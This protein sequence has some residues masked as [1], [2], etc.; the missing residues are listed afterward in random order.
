MKRNHNIQSRLTRT[1]CAVVSAA[2]LVSNLSIYLYLRQIYN[3]ELVNNYKNVGENLSEQLENDLVNIENFARMVCFDT[4]LQTLMRKHLLYEDYMYYRTIREINSALAQYVAL[5]DDLIDD[6]Y[7]VDQE[8]TIISRNGFYADT[9]SSGWFG[10]FK[11]QNVNFSFTG[12]H[13]VDRR[14]TNFSSE[15]KKVISYIV[16]MFDLTQ[17]VK[18]SGLMGYVIVNIKYDELMG[19]MESFSEFQGMLFGRNGEKIGG[20]DASIE[21]PGMQSEPSKTEYFVNGTYYFLSDLPSADW[22][23]VS[24]VK[25]SVLNMQVLHVAVLSFG[26]MLLI[27]LCAGR[28]IAILSRNITGPLKTLTTGIR[29]FSEGNYETHVEV[30]S[31]DEVEKIAVVFNQMVDNIKRQMEENQRK[32][33]EKRKSQMRFLIAQIKPHFIYNSLNCIIYLARR[34]RNEDI[35]LYTRAFI[36]LLQV[37]IKADP[38]QKTP[39]TEEVEYLRNY[40][41]LI[42][43]RYEH[44]PEFSWTIGSSCYDMRL[45]VLIL[46]PLIENSVFHGILPSGEPGQIHLSVTRE[47][48]GVR[49][50]VRDDGCGIDPDRLQ[51]IREE[52][53]TASAVSH[54]DP[55]IGLGNVNDRLKLC[56]GEES[57]LHIESERGRGTEVWF[58]VVYESEEVK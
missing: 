18:A 40:I 13:E 30:N 4:N 2:L 11:N 46:Q 29:Q 14:E 55:H 28:V 3:K 34:E 7:I 17:A 24:S 36:S 43:Y 6:I 56:Y 45:P 57:T 25:A 1:F 35:I 50:S 26:I 32:E 31:G 39:L 54:E 12:V 10:N 27:M 37:S 19:K 41:T 44:A 53:E 47:G 16:S 49:V 21:L 52:L 42:R 22:V 15:P 9:C 33:R 48:N 20:T 23:L 38:Q 58:W 51:E 8:D 5:R